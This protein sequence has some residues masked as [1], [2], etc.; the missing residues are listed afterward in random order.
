MLDCSSGAGLGTCETEEPRCANES[1]QPAGTKLKAIQWQVQHL[2]SLPVFLAQIKGIASD[3]K[4]SPVDRNRQITDGMSSFMLDLTSLI[5]LFPEDAP[6]L[7]ILT[8]GICESFC[9]SRFSLRQRI[10]RVLLFSDLAVFI[11]ERVKKL[12]IEFEDSPAEILS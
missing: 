12:G 6:R 1:K 7:N 4:L 8:D 2:R 10:E 3:R 9:G 5:T 11:L